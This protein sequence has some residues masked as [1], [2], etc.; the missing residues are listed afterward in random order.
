[1]NKQTDTSERFYPVGKYKVWV[2]RKDGSITDEEIIHN[3]ITTEGIN[4][5]QDVYF[6]GSS[7]TATWYIG[8][9]TGTYTPVITATA[10]TIASA[11]TETSSYDESNRVAYN[12]AAAS[13]RVTS[14][15]ANP[16]EFTASAT[17]AVKGAF[18]ISSA[19]KQ[20]TSGVLFSVSNFS[21]TK[22]LDDGDKLYIQYD[23]TGADGS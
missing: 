19:T 17:I 14:N 12:E 1:V 20:G 7:Q 13:S 9:Y 5:M 18:L 6:H 11:A 2:K 4:N 16:A 8:I 21:S 10:A 23:I 3:I 22:N 15:S